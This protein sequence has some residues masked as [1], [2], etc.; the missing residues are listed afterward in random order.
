MHFLLTVSCQD[1]VE[2]S[3]PASLYETVNDYQTHQEVK[4]NIFLSP[5]Q[6]EYLW[7][8]Q[9]RQLGEERAIGRDDASYQEMTSARSEGIRMTNVENSQAFTYPPFNDNQQNQGIAS[10]ALR[11]TN[12]YFQHHPCPAAAS[13]SLSPAYAHMTAIG[14][15][16]ISPPI[17][18]FQSGGGEF[19][20]TED[21]DQEYTA[22][23]QAGTLSSQTGGS[24]AMNQQGQ[25]TSG[26][27]GD[28]PVP[29]Y[30]TVNKGESSRPQKITEC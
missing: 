21:D 26:A 20:A 25:S 5:Q 15:G 12:P 3:S 10:G 13:S 17:M 4:A 28:M 7:K 30:S 1:G 22:M 19:I 23:S 9:H 16:P 2:T 6:Q 24:R 11:F 29:M 18:V 14:S 8:V 27:S